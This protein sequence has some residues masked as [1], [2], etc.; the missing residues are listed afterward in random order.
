MFY[1]KE[2]HKLLGFEKARNLK[3]KYDA[4]IVNKESGKIIRIPF[5]A[6]SQPQYKDSTG[7]GLW[8]EYNHGD[9]I[10]R[11][12]FRSRHKKN[13]DPDYYSPTYFSWKYLW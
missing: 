7:L 11:E 13:Y 6:A 12:L 5:G 3:K 9:P 1:S 4:I 2:K 8:V 10:R